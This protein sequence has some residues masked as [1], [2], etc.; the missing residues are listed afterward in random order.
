MSERLRSVKSLHSDQT[1]IR[2]RRIR[3]RESRGIF[4]TL[5]EIERPVRVCHRPGC[6]GRPIR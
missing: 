4:E 1:V 5:A 3:Q 6:S 2:G